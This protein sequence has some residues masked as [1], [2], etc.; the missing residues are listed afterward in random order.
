MDNFGNVAKPKFYPMM[1]PQTF[2]VALVAFKKKPEGG[3]L[4]SREVSTVS[5]V[6]EEQI[7]LAVKDQ[8]LKL[9]P[10]EEGWFMHQATLDRV[11]MPV[12]PAES[13]E[14]F[15]HVWVLLVYRELNTPNQRV[16]MGLAN[17]VTPTQSIPDGVDPLAMLYEKMPE[18]EGWEGHSSEHQLIEVHLIQNPGHSLRAN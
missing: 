14:A 10:R 18:A 2:V 17:S 3:Y 5:G 7:A 8:S 11:E 12:L 9:F 13:R 1:T 16:V 6:D 15:L 4:V